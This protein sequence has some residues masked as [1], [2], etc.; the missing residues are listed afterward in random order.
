MEV[1]AGA[2]V[3]EQVEDGSGAVYAGPAVRKLAREFGVLLDRVS[4]SGTR[5]RI[6]KEDL[7]HYVAS[8]LASPEKDPSA[9]TSLPAVPEVDFARFGT[10]ESLSRGRID[11]LTASNMVRSWL[12]VP[13][14]TQFDDADISDL[15]QFR[16]GMKSEAEQRG[17]RLSPLPFILKACALALADQHPSWRLNVGTGEDEEQER[18]TLHVTMECAHNLV[19]LLRS[20]GST[21]KAYSVMR[22]YLSY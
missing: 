2:S 16:K 21:N 14:V 9:A 6:L 7:Q 13:H 8:A 1:A 17:V 19:T 15:E 4:G 11:K 18:V 5:G 10:I 12:N 22:K 20:S 3:V